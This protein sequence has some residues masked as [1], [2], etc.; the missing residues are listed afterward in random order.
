MI[1]FVTRIQKCK[2]Q[3]EASTL[4]RDCSL[5]AV[6]RILS[7]GHPMKSIPSWHESICFI[8]E[9]IDSKNEEKLLNLDLERNY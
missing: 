5:I 8:D 3:G 4:K 7:L 6:V 1:K 9:V 2:T